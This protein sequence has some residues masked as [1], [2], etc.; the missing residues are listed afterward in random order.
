MTLKSLLF[1]STSLLLLAVA[2]SAQGADECMNADVIAPG[3]SSLFVDTNN[4][5]DTSTLATTSAGSACGVSNDVWFQWVSPR[6]GMASFSTCVTGFDTEVGVYEGSDCATMVNLDCNDDN[7]TQGCAALSS[8]VTVLVTAG[9]TYHVQV[10]YWSTSGTTWG[11]TTLFIDEDLPALAGADECV[12][13]DFIGSGDVVTPFDTNVCSDTLAPATTSAMNACTSLTEDLWFR[14]IADSTGGATFGTCGAGFDTEVSVWTGTD[15]GSMVHLGCND[16]SCGLQSEVTINATAGAC[17]YVQVGYWSSAGGVWGA[18]DLTVTESPISDNIGI[19]Y[20]WTNANSTGFQAEISA[21]GSKQITA[22]DVT[23]ITSK[24]PLGEFGYYVAS[25]D[26]AP[27]VA[28]A[29]TGSQGNLCIGGNTSRFVDL[30]GQANVEGVYARPIDLTAFPSNPVIAV[31]PGDTF[32]FICWFRDGMTS[33][34]T[35]G[36]SITFQ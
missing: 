12:H 2:A 28:T 8:S 15:C 21:V 10:G 26:P 3:T 27:A 7:N 14:W 23:L 35:N 36:L 11:E 25:S 19:S 13:A 31:Q 16:D 24:M 17:Y 34:F 32:N 6:T 22:N 9:E 5:S 4:C 18:G 20:C 33:N 30:A 1:S 29:I